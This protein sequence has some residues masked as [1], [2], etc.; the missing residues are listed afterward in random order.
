MELD[1]LPG[2]TVRLGA[3]YRIPTPVCR[4]IY[5]ALLPYD[6]AARRGTALLP[7]PVAQHS[8]PS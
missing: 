5:A 7:G 8:A 6:E 3:R 4:A 1:A 2:H